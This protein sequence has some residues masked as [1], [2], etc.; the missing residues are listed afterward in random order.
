MHYDR[1]YVR[2]VSQFVLETFG[3][4]GSVFEN[5]LHRILVFTNKKRK[6]VGTMYFSE[7][8]FIVLL[9]KLK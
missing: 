8:F 2:A 3:R 7:Y 4:K 1:I 6:A 5:I 9:Q